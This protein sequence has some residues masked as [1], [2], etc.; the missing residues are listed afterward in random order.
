MA[1]RS[2]NRGGAL[3]LSVA[4]TLGLAAVSAGGVARGDTST[5]ELSIDHGAP[6]WL[7]HCL[8]LTKLNAS[9][10]AAHADDAQAVAATSP[11]AVSVR[12]VEQKGRGATLEIRA[13]RAQRDLGSRVLS[14]HANDCGAVP[15]AV[16]LVLVL[17]SRSAGQAP[18]P[19][20][21]DS[22]PPQP[23]PAPAFDPELPPAL[24]PP[25]PEEDV[26]LRVRGSVVM[27]F[28][29]G[30]L[31]STAVGLGLDGELEFAPWALRL[32]AQLLWPQARQVAEGRVELFPFGLGID[33]CL[34]ST[35]VGV[36]WLELRAC[37]G[38]RVSL[39]HASGSR[40]RLQNRAPLEPAL[41]LGGALE[42]AAKLAASTWIRLHFD[43]GV[44]LLRPRF[45]VE[46]QGEA[47]PSEVAGPELLRGEVGLSVVQIF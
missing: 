10:R 25:E 4:W 1:P 17:L 29:R 16:A 26:P 6:A 15:D 12:A 28:V 43:G 9:Y 35:L 44:A 5:V 36:P 20:L 27:S 23:L 41:H 11:V 37:A 30:V 14:V 47:E 40:F 45:V 33:G 7:A 24:A 46:V 8:S 34:G 3:G 32:R 31:P 13:Q 18:P 2:I 42:G 19:P 39:I 21:P 38:P 22:P